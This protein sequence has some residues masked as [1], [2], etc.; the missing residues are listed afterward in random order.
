MLSFHVAV[1]F[2]KRGEMVSAS[3]SQT[4]HGEGPLVVILYL[5]YFGRILQKIKTND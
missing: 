5:V 3:A 4:T 1:V 2:G